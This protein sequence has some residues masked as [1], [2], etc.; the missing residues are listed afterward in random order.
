[1]AFSFPLQLGAMSDSDEEMQLIN[2]VARLDSQLEAACCP[3]KEKLYAHLFEKFNDKPLTKRL[4]LWLF[5]KELCQK[6][7]DDMLSCSA[8]SA[9]S[10]ETVATSLPV[11]KAEVYERLKQF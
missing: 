9:S 4:K 7:V 11:I 1:M 8:P 6:L 5:R 3:F 2:D 10:G